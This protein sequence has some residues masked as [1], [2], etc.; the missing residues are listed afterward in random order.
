MP[1]NDRRFRD[2]IRGEVNSIE[3]RCAGYQEVLADTLDQIIDLERIHPPKIQQKVSDKCNR[4]G[5][6]LAAEGSLP[7]HSQ[8]PL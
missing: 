7:W 4:A 8:P 6:W 1:L 2:I 5:R 3:E